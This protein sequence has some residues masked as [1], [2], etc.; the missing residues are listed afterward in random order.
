[1]A[2]Y[3]FA[4]HLCGRREDA[5]DVTQFVFLQAHRTLASGTVLEHPRAWLMTAAKRRWLTILRDRHDTPVDPASLEFDDRRDPSPDADHELRDVRANLW[6]L[7]EQQHQA[8]VLRHWSGLSYQ[9]IA[10]VLGTTAAAVESLLVRARASLLRD[11]D[12][13]GECAGVRRALERDR[14]LTAQ[15]RD[16]LAGCSR[17]RTA[18]TRLAQVAGIAGVLA[19][20][21]RQHVAEAL[22]STLP[23]F[24][25]GAA[26]PAGGAALAGGGGGAAGGATSAVA[27]G[28]KLAVA[29]KVATAVGA[30]TLALTAAHVVRLPGAPA[31]LAD[32]AGSSI[33]NA[34]RHTGQS[35]HGRAATHAPQTGH[36]RSA[37]QGSSGSSGSAPAAAGPGPTP[38]AT[39]AGHG[40]PPANTAAGGSTSPAAIAG[41]STHGSGGSSSGRSLSNQP[42]TGSGRSSPAGGHGRP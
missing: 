33:N 38:A 41:G 42:Q 40:A 12:Q 24:S 17:C 26:A 19:L 6:A 10:E 30:A 34:A 4:F 28:G 31:P 1:M 27:A 32:H 39:A 21:P 8:F 5:E 15:M 35:E 9:E 22:A 36:G 3:R 11:R 14:G 18:R 20:A 7:P 29:V 23:G 2:V 25:A 16:H 37:G 13:A